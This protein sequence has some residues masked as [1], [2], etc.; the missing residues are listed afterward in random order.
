MKSFFMA[1]LWLEAAIGLLCILY[2]GFAILST[3][4]APLRGGLSAVIESFQ[5]GRCR[6]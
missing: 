2:L 1:I 6:V 3:L 4:T 5:E